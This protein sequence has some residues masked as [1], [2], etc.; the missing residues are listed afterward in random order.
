MRKLN[1]VLFMGGDSGEYEVSIGS[2][3]QVQNNLE[4]EKYN[5]FPVLVR[6]GKWIYTTEN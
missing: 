2:A 5:V 6:D 3:S 1:V 4:A